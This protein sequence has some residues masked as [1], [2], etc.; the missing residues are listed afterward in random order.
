[1]KL[2]I[3]I[4]IDDIVNQNSPDYYKIKKSLCQKK[5]RK[6]IINCFDG[7]NYNYFIFF[8]CYPYK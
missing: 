1:M 2:P 8:D 4:K 3:G 6:P 7:I 5:Y